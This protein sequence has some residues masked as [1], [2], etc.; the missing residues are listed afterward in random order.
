MYFPGSAISK[1]GGREFQKEIDSLKASQPSINTAEGRPDAVVSE[2][3]LF[4][5]PT[6]VTLVTN[7][8]VMHTTSRKGL[9]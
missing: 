6:K 4:Q 2:H 7:L 5:S 9:S 1:A 3:I 8:A